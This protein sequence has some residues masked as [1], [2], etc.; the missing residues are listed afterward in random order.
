MLRI[1]LEEIQHE[2]R[3]RRDVDEQRI[4]V[5]RA[6]ERERQERAIGGDA[7]IRRRELI[8]RERHAPFERMRF[9]Q[10]GE[11]SQPERGRERREQPEDHR[12]VRERDDPA[13]DDRRDRRRNAE[14]H[15]HG[16][17]QPLRFDAVEAVAD[18]RAADDEAGAGRDALQRAEREQ[19]ADRTGQ[20]AADRRQ[21]EHRDADEDHAPPT[22]RVGQRAVEQ[23][24]QR[25]RDH[26]DADRLLHRDRARAELA[27]DRRETRERSC[28]SRTARTSPARRAAVPDGAGAG[29]R[30]HSSHADGADSSAA[31]RLARADGFALAY[32][33][34]PGDGIPPRTAARLMMPDEFPENR[35]AQ[36]RRLFA[37]MSAPTVSGSTI[38]PGAS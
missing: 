32:L 21:R 13:A 5:Q 12:P 33:R 38:D 1:E 27:R 23:R 17:H 10:P 8:E 36:V 11:T 20:R 19:R 34:N 9:R 14:D 31:P 37:A 29:K 2:R 28:R 7:S 16:R 24:H 22:E 35:D 3:R 18:D 30:R 26:V 25:I 6:G 15:R 4:E